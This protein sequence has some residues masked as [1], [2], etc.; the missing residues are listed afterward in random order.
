MHQPLI[1]DSTP[2]DDQ[3]TTATPQGCHVPLLRILGWPDIFSLHAGQIKPKEPVCSPSGGPK[4]RNWLLHHI[5]THVIISLVT[6]GEGR[7]HPTC[8]GEPFPISGAYPNTRVG[9]VWLTKFCLVVF[10]N[11][12]ASGNEVDLAVLPNCEEL[13]GGT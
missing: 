11:P 4:W 8:T 10:P 13:A 3:Q 2:R 7:S 9:S 5:H 1:V 6:F 12:D